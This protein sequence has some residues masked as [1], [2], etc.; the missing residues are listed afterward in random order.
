MGRAI[1]AR[2]GASHEAFQW[3][4]RALQ[5]QPD[6]AAGHLLLAELFNQCQQ[7]HEALA[8]Y[9]RVVALA[10]WAPHEA[11]IAQQALEQLEPEL[12]TQASGWGELARQMLGLLII[13]I[14]GALANAQLRLIN[15]SLLAWGAIA[16]SIVGAY[17]W[18]SAQ[19]M[20]RNPL[21]RLV[22]GRPDPQ[23]GPRRLAGML[24]F[25]LWLIA[26]IATLL[27]E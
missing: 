9:R 4:E 5:Q 22:F 7:P 1:A 2:D 10:E 21:S 6:L 16:L 26:C 12:S 13:P 11:Q 15:I 14:L 24:G 25:S 18:V 8:H 23:P 27:I 19:E 20:P 3:V 17:L